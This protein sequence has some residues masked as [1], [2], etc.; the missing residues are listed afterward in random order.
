MLQ[1]LLC[2]VIIMKNTIKNFSTSV[3]LIILIVLMG[4]ATNLND[5]EIYLACSFC[6]AGQYLSKLFMY[7][8]NGGK[9]I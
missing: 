5:S 6:I 9:I 7:V 1:Q 2:D 8:F 3:I 4:N